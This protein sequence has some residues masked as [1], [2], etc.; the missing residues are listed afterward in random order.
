[1]KG[2][3]S[4]EARPEN[5]P[6]PGGEVNSGNSRIMESNLKRQTIH[7]KLPPKPSAPVS[8]GASAM[9]LPL[10]GQRPNARPGAHDLPLRITSFILVSLVAL[11]YCHF[12]FEYVRG[13]PL[14]DFLPII[15]W[16]E[17]VHKLLGAAILVG[18]VLFERDRKM[19]PPRSRWLYC[20]LLACGIALF[21]FQWI[22]HW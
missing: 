4:S 1:M 14:Q 6:P 11:A 21:A 12:I 22:I 5:K 8:S 20:T 9:A 19:L 15:L 17:M 18:F 16:P 7:I 2:D 13:L 10:R 3:E